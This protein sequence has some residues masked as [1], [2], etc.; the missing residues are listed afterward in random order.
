MECKNDEC[1]EHLFDK[2]QIIYFLGHEGE[3]A[4]TDML[5]VRTTQ[6]E[7]GEIMMCNQLSWHICLNNEC[8][9][10]YY[11]KSYNGFNKKSFLG[12]RPTPMNEL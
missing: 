6:T 7:A 12:L 5:R 8:D 4:H 9:W 11:Q 3:E 10:H 2:Q 1:T